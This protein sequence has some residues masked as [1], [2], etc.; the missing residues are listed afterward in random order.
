[1]MLAIDVCDAV[2]QPAQRIHAE[3]CFARRNEMKVGNENQFQAVA[4]VLD[5]SINVSSCSR[6]CGAQPTTGAPPSRL[7]STRTSFA[8]PPASRMMHWAARQ[9]QAFI[10][11]S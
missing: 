2:L 11:G 10:C 4:S 1:G 5:V 8:Q 3:Q 7:P 9:S 6:I